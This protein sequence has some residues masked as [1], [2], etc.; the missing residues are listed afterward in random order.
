MLYK[1]NY[2]IR[3]ACEDGHEVLVIASDLEYHDGRVRRVPVPNETTEHGYTLRRLPYRKFLTWKIADKIRYVPGLRREIEEFAPDLL[4]FNVPQVPSITNVRALKKRSAAMRIVCVFS[5]TYDNSARAFIS[6]RILHGWLYRR[7]LRK[8]A[9]F[10][11]EIFYVAPESKQF[12]TEVYDLPPSR[13]SLLPLP[14]ELVAGEMKRALRAQFRERHGFASDD[15]VFLHAGKMDS[16]KKTLPLIRAFR[17]L[18][19]RQCHLVLAGSFSADIADDVAEILGED[20]RIHYVGFLNPHNLVSALCSADLYLQPGSVSHIAQ[21][22]MCCGTPVMLAD[23]PIYR[24]LLRQNG[25]LVESSNDIVNIL[26]CAASNPAQLELMGANSYAV[27][28]EVLDFRVLFRRMAHGIGS[29][30]A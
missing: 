7:W 5:T 2:F 22:A 16:R 18:G 4:Y 21:T 26:N 20:D 1:E 11:N 8:A 10:L 13:L 14:G 27:A 12:V 9:P 28:Q 30:K 29:E 23:R 3:A 19:R 24:D 15:L 17:S 25:F 6:R